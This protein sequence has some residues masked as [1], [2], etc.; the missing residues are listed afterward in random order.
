M[1]GRRDPD[2]K[3]AAHQAVAWFAWSSLAFQRAAWFFIVL[4]IHKMTPVQH[5]WMQLQVLAGEGGLVPPNWCLW[6]SKVV[7]IGLDKNSSTVDWG[8]WKG[9]QLIHHDLLDLLPSKTLGLNSFLF[10]P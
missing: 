10:L 6:P 2:Y 5:L 8:Q 1:I 9:L 4:L 7:I 3:Q